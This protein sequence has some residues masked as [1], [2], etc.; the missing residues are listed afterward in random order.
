MPTCVVVP[1]LKY[2]CSQPWSP[3]D[4]SH[5]YSIALVRWSPGALSLYYSR[6]P[7]QVFL[8]SWWQNLQH[9]WQVL[10]PI[11]G[12]IWAWNM[13]GNGLIAWRAGQS[14]HLQGVSCDVVPVLQSGA[15]HA[16]QG[17]MELPPSSR[18]LLFTALAASHLH[19]STSLCFYCTRWLGYR[20]SSMSDVQAGR[21]VTWL[22]KSALPMTSAL[23]LGPQQAPCLC[24][25]LTGLD[26]FL[27]RWLLSTLGNLTSPNKLKSSLLQ[28]P[29]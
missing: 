21:S 17:V 6:T 26:G 11:H 2:K 19:L 14:S 8:Q 23:G 4:I 5:T 16:C 7:I 18:H 22:V 28:F 12:W 10:S 3:D 25:A 29:G 1:L 15:S 27:Q 24:S 13:W 9:T 20:L